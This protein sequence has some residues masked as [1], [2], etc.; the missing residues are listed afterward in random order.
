MKLSIIIVNYHV[1]ELL[2]KCLDSIYK[3]TQGIEFEIIVVDN[4]EKKR[5][6][7]DIKRRFPQVKYLSNE[8]R[9]FAQANN[10]G[11]KVASGAY[12]FFL[13]PDTIVYK[14]CTRELISFLDKNKKAGIVAPVLYNESQ[15]PY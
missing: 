14:N 10:A 3:T 2:F 15:K 6:A 7:A 5:I 8:N 13:N 12:L 4:D 1:K 9:G 11:V